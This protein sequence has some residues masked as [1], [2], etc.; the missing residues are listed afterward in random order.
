[1]KIK[2]T[3]LVMIVVLLSAC[4]IVFVSDDDIDIAE[5]EQVTVLDEIRLKAYYAAEFYLAGGM[6][7]E[8]GGD[9]EIYVPPYSTRGIDCSGLAINVYKFAVEG[10]NYSMPFTDATADT[11]YHNYSIDIDTPQKGDLIFW[12]DDSD[13][14]YH[15]AVFEKIESSRY[16]FIESN[17][18]TEY[19]VDGV[20]K[21]SMSVDTTYDIS[22]KRFVVMGNS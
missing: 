14:A 7:Y 10:S 12:T 13:H 16:Y 18:L 21:R 15:I 6:K 20:G 2:Y 11:I 22:V 3:F 4:N 8:L 17:I 9:D 5:I 1:M 19:T